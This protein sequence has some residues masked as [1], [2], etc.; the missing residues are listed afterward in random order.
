MNSTMSIR[1][2]AEQ[3]L[4]DTIN[5]S[6]TAEEV[7]NLSN[8]DDNTAKAIERFLKNVYNALNIKLSSY[9]KGKKYKLNQWLMEYLTNF[10]NNHNIPTAKYIRESFKYANNFSYECLKVIKNFNKENFSG[11]TYEKIKSEVITQRNKIYQD[12][13][14]SI[15]NQQKAAET[16]GNF[17]FALISRKMSLS[18]LDSFIIEVEHCYK[19]NPT[20]ENDHITEKDIILIDFLRLP[21]ILKD[22]HKKLNEEIIIKNILNLNI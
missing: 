21:T 18:E 12:F 9:T 19:E 4:E 22:M 7:D 2:L 20:T 14:I 11:E 10:V 16:F 6:L 1:G 3:I 8:M 17:T 15:Q 5:D 13:L